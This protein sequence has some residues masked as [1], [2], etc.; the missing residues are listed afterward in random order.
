MTSQ[1]S[2][3]DFTQLDETMGYLLASARSY[4]D[5]PAHYVPTR[6]LEGVH[7]I[8]MVLAKQEAKYQWLLEQV[9]EAKALPLH[10]EEAYLAKMDAILV[11]WVNQI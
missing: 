3:E 11:E 6:L 5:E 10:D 1:L 4:V 7:G 8:L 9:E 2:P